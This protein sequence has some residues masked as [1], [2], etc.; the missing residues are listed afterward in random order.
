MTMT[1]TQSKLLQ[2][3][4][5]TIAGALIG[6]GAQALTLGGRVAAI[7]AAQVRIEVRLDQLLKQGGAK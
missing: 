5:T 7:E 6:W 3:L 2:A 4:G 1:D